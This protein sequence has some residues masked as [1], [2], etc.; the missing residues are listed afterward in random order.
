MA[1]AVVRLDE[2]WG[3]FKDA[4]LDDGKQLLLE[5]VQAALAAL[6]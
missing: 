1:R 2:E 5:R 3:A 4:P 6:R